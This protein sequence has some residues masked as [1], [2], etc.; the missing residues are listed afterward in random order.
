[1]M[2]SLLIN[3]VVLTTVFS[4]LNFFFFNINQN[5]FDSNKNFN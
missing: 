2:L 3:S 4:G 5:L 1:M